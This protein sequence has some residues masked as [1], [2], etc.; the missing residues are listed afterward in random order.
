VL[1]LALS[2]VCETHASARRA[3]FRDDEEGV[4]M[5]PE[6]RAFEAPRRKVPLHDS[7][8]YP[9]EVTIVRTRFHQVKF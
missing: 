8:L 6:D 3:E 9:L 7:D 4:G 5:R 1:A 2:L